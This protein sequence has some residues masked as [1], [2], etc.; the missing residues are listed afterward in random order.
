MGKKRVLLIFLSWLLWQHNE[1][2]ITLKNFPCSDCL[3]V[4]LCDGL[5]RLALLW[6]CHVDSC[7]QVRWS[8]SGGRLALCDL[9]SGGCKYTPTQSSFIK[10]FKKFWSKSKSCSRSL[11]K[12]Q[13]L[14]GHC[15]HTLL[16]NV[17][18]NII[19][20]NPDSSS[21]FY[22]P[23][24]YLVSMGKPKSDRNAC[25]V[26]GWD[27]VKQSITSRS[28]VKV[29]ISTAVIHCALTHTHT[30]VKYSFIHC[31]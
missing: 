13:L 21:L 30:Q 20:T 17:I 3:A 10:S 19:V 27:W 4:F 12:L 14:L 9:I 26:Q 25:R 28:A 15:G 5:R 24:N 6:T 7:D 22:N 18:S 23:N 2:L 29:H 11:R 8:I 31:I 1:P 16:S